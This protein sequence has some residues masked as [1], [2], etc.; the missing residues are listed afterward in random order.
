MSNVRDLA[1]QLDPA[2]WVRKVLG[3]EPMAWQEDFLRAPRGASI[4]ALTARQ[5]G[6]TTTAAWAMTHT[7]LYRPGSLSVVACPAQRQSAEAVRRVRDC[8]EKAGARRVTDNVYG[9]ELENGARVMALPGSE[10]SIRGLTVDGWIVADEAAR[11][12][13]AMIAALRPMR[14][15]CPEARFAMLST[16][17][18]RTDPFW[19]AW[20][21]DNQTW[22]RLRATAE[23]GILSEE[24]LAQEY[25]ALGEAAFKA[26]YLGIPMGGE[27]SP[28]TWELYE[29]AT[30][31]HVPK[32]PAGPAFAPSPEAQPVPMTNPFQQHN[33]WRTK[34]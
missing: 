27:G 23:S 19:T 30:T 1:C 31:P 7:A 12:P 28:F 8:L 17:W 21:S 10:D 4:L 9:L 15:R 32:V 26:E 18:S 33:P 2:L 14:A 25:D 20:E 13:A 5:I 34:P 29:R 6:K 3:F 16:A 22:M 11:L 24:F